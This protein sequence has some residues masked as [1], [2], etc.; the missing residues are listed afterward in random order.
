M[1]KIRRHLTFA[2]V[3]ACLALFF[4]L[5]GTVY[6]GSK[7][8]GKTI[9]KNTLP[10]NR[11]KKNTL[12]GNK[13][14]KKTLAANKIKKNAITG[15]QINESKLGQVPNAAN[16][17]NAA[18]VDSVKTFSAG[19]NDNQIVSLVKTAN[20]ELVGICDP[21]GDFPRRREAA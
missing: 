17:A 1:G 14:K 18:N 3:V 7:I 20:F 6:A 16:A 10:G 13:I 9:K 12:P 15:A 21:N 19:A 2:N 11:I 4:A 5:G 8:N